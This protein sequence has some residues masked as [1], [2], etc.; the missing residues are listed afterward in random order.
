MELCFLAGLRGGLL[1]HIHVASLQRGDSKG[2]EEGKGDKG[3]VRDYG[4]SFAFTPRCVC[5]TDTCDGLDYGLYP[6][7]KRVGRD[8]C[9]PSTPSAFSPPHPRAIPPHPPYLSRQ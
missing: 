8:S 7:A 1:V 4:E 2:R 6:S 5:D 9:H 3:G